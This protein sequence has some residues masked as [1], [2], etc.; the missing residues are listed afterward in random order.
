MTIPTKEQCIKILK[1]NN[2]PDN[3]I[4]HCKA[5]CDFSMNII[6]L[7]EKRGIN[8]NRDLVIASALLHDIKKLT[9]GDHVLEGYEFV[10]SLSYP[11]VALIIKR[12]G[13]V[14]LND[15]DFAPKT[16]E[17]KIVFYADKRVKDNKVVSVAERFEYIKQKYNHYD[18]EKELKFTKKIEKELLIDNQESF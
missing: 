7:L 8:V 18:V 1:E 3:I 9:E 13:L 16:W 10:K 4:A 5:V 17:D 12:H 6:Y 2:V 11:V 14:H 15:E